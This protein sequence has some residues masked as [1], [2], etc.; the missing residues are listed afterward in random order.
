MESVRAVVYLSVCLSVLTSICQGQRS[1][2][3][4]L[5]SG[6][7]ESVM[8]LTTKDLVSRLSSH[9]IADTSGFYSESLTNVFEWKNQFPVLKLKVFLD[10]EW[11]SEELI[12]VRTS[13]NDSISINQNKY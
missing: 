5:P 10:Y 7:D 2:D 4:R 8:G 9:R 13:N 12:C 1:T 3:S 11:I 6:P